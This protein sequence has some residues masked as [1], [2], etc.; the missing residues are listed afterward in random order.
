MKK[1]PIFFLMTLFCATMF[2]QTPCSETQSDVGYAYSHAKTAYNANNLT[3]LKE[4]ANRS[5]EAFKRVEPMLK[6]C[7]CPD[8]YYETSPTVT[9]LASASIAVT[10]WPSFTVMFCSS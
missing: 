9:V 1:T 4:Y 3:Q 10:R 7:Q 8:A 5:L 6:D 2:A